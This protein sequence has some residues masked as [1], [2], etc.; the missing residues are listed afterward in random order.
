MEDLQWDYYPFWLIT[1]HWPGSIA[2][3]FDSANGAVRFA[4]IMIIPM[5]VNLG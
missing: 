4:P 2:A 1:R 5:I 3:S